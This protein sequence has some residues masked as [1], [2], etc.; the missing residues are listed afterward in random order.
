MAP[1]VNSN[2]KGATIC[3]VTVQML[4]ANDNVLGTETVMN[5]TSH[6]TEWITFTKSFQLMSGTRKLKYTVR[7]QDALYWG[8][9]YGPYFRNLSMKAA[10]K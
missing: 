1:H 2:G 4:D 7:G 10:T 5:D 3:E 6:M 8:G 9:N